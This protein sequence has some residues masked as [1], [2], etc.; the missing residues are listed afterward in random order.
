MRVGVE[1]PTQGRDGSVREHQAA[2]RF[3]LPLTGRHL[4]RAFHA[5]H[6]ARENAAAVVAEGSGSIGPVNRP[7]YRVPSLPAQE[8]AAQSVRFTATGKRFLKRVGSARA[9]PIVRS[10]KRPCGRR[11]IPA[12]CHLALNARR[13]VPALRGQGAEFRYCVCGMIRFRA[14]STAPR[15]GVGHLRRRR[16]QEATSNTQAPIGRPVGE[17]QLVAHSAFRPSGDGTPWASVT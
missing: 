2:S 6:A 12:T 3:V 7:S 4:Q 14:T 15:S 5:A 17:P 8:R 13:P 11:H 16:H 10:E 1:P 9:N